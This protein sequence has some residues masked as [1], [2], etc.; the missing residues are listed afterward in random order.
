MAQ[1]QNP[2]L[3]RNGGGMKRST[4]NPVAPE[5]LELARA[6]ARQAAREDHERENRETVSSVARG[7][8][9]TATGRCA[10]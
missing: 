2:R 1:R 9:Q 8:L 6:L 5:I 3:E 10:A 7:T 4:A